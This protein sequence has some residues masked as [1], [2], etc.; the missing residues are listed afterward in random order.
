MPMR[1][2]GIANTKIIFAA[3]SN[4]NAA[5]FEESYACLF[6]VYQRRT[7]RCSGTR[8]VLDASTCCERELASLATLLACTAAGASLQAA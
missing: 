2:G 1:L 4:R 7:V 8:A 5:Y 6:K 3:A